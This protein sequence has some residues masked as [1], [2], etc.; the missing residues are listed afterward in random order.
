VSD[1]IGCDQVTPEI[2]VTAT[3]VIDR[4]AGA[5]GIMYVMSMSKD[6]TNYHQILHALDITTGADA[7]PPQEVSANFTDVNGN[8]TSFAP[9]QYE[10]RAAMLLSN[11]TIYTTWSSH[12][13]EPPYGGWIITYNQTTLAQNGVL[14]VGPGSAGSTSASVGPG[15]WMSGGGPAVD[16]AGNVYL[17]TGNGPFDTTLNANGHPVNGNYGQSFLKLQSNGSALSVADYFALSNGPTESAADLDLGSGGGLLLP[18]MTNSSNNPVNL[19]VGAGKDS[20]IYI[21]DQADLGGFDA[22]ANDIHQQVNGALGG[23]IVLATPAYFDNHL[24]FGARDLGV[25]S[26]TLSQAK[27]STTAS[28]TSATIFSYPG[29]SPSVSA[30]GTSN[31]ILWAHRSTATAA[32]LYAFDATDLT[33]ELYNST[34]AAGSRDAFG[35]SNKFIAPVVTGGKVF[36]GAATGVAIF[37]LLP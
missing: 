13:D 22:G 15:I 3:P 19:Y 30:N 29:T 36:V 11:G 17:L 37:G 16:A 33:I 6:A 4:T 28:S 21:V 1:D 14:N 20:N 18:T 9:A 35:A 26:F 25:K 27:L 2:G 32:Q 31:G 7:I 5:H 8:V 12:C 24:Y 34:Q 23:R 10:E